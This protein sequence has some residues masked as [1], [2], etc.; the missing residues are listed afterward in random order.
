[1]W[2]IVDHTCDIQ[3]NGA[4]TRSEP[5]AE[6]GWEWIRPPSAHV[7]LSTRAGASR[8]RERPA[9]RCR[10]GLEF[11]TVTRAIDAVI[12]DMDGTLIDSM[13]PVNDAFVETIVAAGGPTY[14]HDEIISA[15]PKGPS[16]RMLTH[17]LGRP[18]AEEESA[19]YHRRL[20]EK[21]ISLAP[22]P[23]ITEVLDA[24]AVSKRL[25]V[26][27]GAGRVSLRMLLGGTGL[28]DRFEVTT[29]GDEVQDAK[30]APDGILLTCERLGVDPTRAAYVGDS[31]PDMEAARAAGSIAVG[32]AWGSLWQSSHR[33]D[34]TARVPADLVALLG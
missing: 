3:P 34:L 4:L 28:L 21:A 30:P 5:V 11:P 33:A 2:T 10:N 22:Y 9:L 19:D 8:R 1:M 18:V 12:F 25:A 26:F 27:T 23:G 31:G 32:A 15:F 24:L 14:T 29:G 13:D 7:L 17:L 20:D 16:D 6:D